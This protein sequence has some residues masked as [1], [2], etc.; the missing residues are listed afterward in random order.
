MLGYISRLKAK[1][2]NSVIL[3]KSNQK[4]SFIHAMLSIDQL[5]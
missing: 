3:S 1:N 5:I 4:G 2:F